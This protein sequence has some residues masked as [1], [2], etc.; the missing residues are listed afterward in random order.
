MRIGRIAALAVVAGLL[1]GCGGGAATPSPSAFASDSVAI[2]VDNG[3]DLKLSLVVGSV[4]VETLA[5]HS[6][7]RALPRSAL[8]TLPWAVTVRTE[9]GRILASFIVQSTYSPTGAAQYEAAAGLSCGQ[10]YL[11]TGASEPS[12]PAPASGNPGDCL[13]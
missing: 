6:A 11:W 8:P 7:D 12:W 3:T 5:P 2:G 10:V 13:P 9:S 4:V 1:G